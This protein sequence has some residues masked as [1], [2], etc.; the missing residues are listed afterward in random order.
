MRLFLVASL[1]LVL[2]CSALARA[3]TI[4]VEWNASPSITGDLKGPLGNADAPC[5]DEAMPYCVL[6]PCYA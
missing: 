6:K 5:R 3:I 1:L 4:E 2:H